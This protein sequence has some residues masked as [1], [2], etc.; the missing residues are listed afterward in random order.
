MVISASA[1]SG[2]R[3]ASLDRG[4][5]ATK[6]S[7]LVLFRPP[8][9]T[10]PPGCSRDLPFPTITDPAAPPLRP[11][12]HVPDS[13]ATMRRRL[14]AALVKTLPRCHAAQ[15]PS[16]DDHHTEI[17]DGVRL[18]VGCESPLDRWKM[19]RHLRPLRSRR[20]PSRYHKADPRRRASSEHPDGFR[21]N[22]GPKVGMKPGT[23]QQ[24]DG[25]PKNISD[26]ALDAKKFTKSN[27]SEL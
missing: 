9:Q 11:E 26:I 1:P 19:S 7:R 17:C 12:R 6:H 20:S 3:A 27:S 15:R 2:R 14:V 8:Q 24:V 13:I 21:S 22:I 23:G 10:I 16:S 25:A 4:V 5:A 18:Y